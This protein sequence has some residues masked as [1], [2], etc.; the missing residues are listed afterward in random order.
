[1]LTPA[2]RK[3]LKAKAHKLDPVVHIGAKGLTDEVIAEIDRALHAHE[4]IKVRAGEPG[5]RRARRS[6]RADL[7]AAPAPRRCS[8]SARSSCSSGRRTM[9]KQRHAR[10][11]SSCKG[12]VAQGEIET[13]V[14]GFTDHYGRLMGKRFDAEMF[15]EEIA[16]HGGHAC[17][18]LLTV[19]MEME[20][21]PGY[22]FANWE[23]GYGDFHMVPDLGTLRVAS[24]LDKTAFVLCDVKSEKTHDYVAVAP[25]SILRR[26]VDAAKKARLHRL[27]RHRAR[28]LPL[29]DQLPP[30][31]AAGLPRPRARRLVPRGLPHPAGHAHRGL[32]R[33]GAPPPE[34]LRRAGGDLEGRMGPG[35]ARA[36]RALRRGA[37]H[38]RPPRRVQAVPEGDRRGAWA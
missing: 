18:Y 12:M 30:G 35:P 27:C 26:Q 14:V 23:L 20:P 10:R 1:M 5:S 34:A 13:V 37:R 29:P 24:W 4:L 36:Q 38:G 7:R 6:F 16:K 33:R 28:A 3:A 22:R 2:E 32:P 9:N 31:R 8:T 19:D 17:D 15:V 25:R 11:W 21:V